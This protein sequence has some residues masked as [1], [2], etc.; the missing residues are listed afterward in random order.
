VALIA[1]QVQMNN[2]QLLC[3]EKYRLAELYNSL[4]RHHSDRG[5]WIRLP[6]T[7]RTV[8]GRQERSADDLVGFVQTNKEKS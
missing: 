7:Q 2:L 8:I 4:L 1:Q 3:R 6:L 5:R